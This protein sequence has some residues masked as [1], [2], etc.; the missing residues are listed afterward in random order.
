MDEAQKTMPNRGSQNRKE[1][2]QVELE[3]KSKL[4]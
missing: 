4:N 1:Q 3:L 2:L